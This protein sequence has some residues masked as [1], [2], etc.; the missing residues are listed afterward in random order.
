[1]GIRSYL[2]QCFCFV[3]QFDSILEGYIFLVYDLGL[4]LIIYINKDKIYIYL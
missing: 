4:F 1:M 2:F 3:R